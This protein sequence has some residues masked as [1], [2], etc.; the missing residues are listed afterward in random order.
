MN[1]KLNLRYIRYFLFFL[2]FLVFSFAIQVFVQ[3]F[4]MNALISD[5]KKEQLSLSWETFWMKHYYEPFLNSTY[6]KFL[7]QHRYWITT[8]REILVKFRSESDLKNS[9]PDISHDNYTN[10]DSNK[11]NQ[12]LRSDFF[13][14]LLSLSFL[15]S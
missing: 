8:E 5:S 7:S 12:Q 4:N 6:S 9:E 15:K 14:E 1:F 11:S 2:S 13:K 10:F 3:N